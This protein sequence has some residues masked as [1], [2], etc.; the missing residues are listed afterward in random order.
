MSVLGY[1]INFIDQDYTTG[2]ARAL[3]NYIGQCLIDFG[4]Q[5]GANEA[6]TYENQFYSP[7]NPPLIVDLPGNPDILDMNRW[8][9]LTL[10][11]FIDQSG[12]PIPG[13]TPD[14]LSPEWGQVSNFALDPSDLTTYNRDGFDYEVYHDPGGPP[15]WTADGSGDFDI[16]QWAF[17]MCVVWSSHLDASDGV[18]WDIS[19]NSI[20][21]RDPFPTDFADFSHVEKSPPGLLA[22]FLW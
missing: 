2:D 3:G 8:Q 22:R 4:L 20:G 21:N 16:Y 7:V 6:G 9:P 13:E 5:D 1:D 15:Q 10:D 19:P 12:N 17:S 11:L 14:F 18:T